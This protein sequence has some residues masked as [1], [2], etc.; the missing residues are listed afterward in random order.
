MSKVYRVLT[1]NEGDIFANVVDVNGYN[2]LRSMISNCNNESVSPFPVHIEKVSD[3]GQNLKVVDLVGLTV[4]S[5][6]ASCDL[7]N[8][9]SRLFDNY[10]YWIQYDVSSMYR[11]FIAN[12]CLNIIDTNLSQIRYYS[13]SGNVMDI[14]DYHFIHSNDL[15]S[16]MIFRSTLAPYREILCTDHFINIYQ[17]LNGSGLAFRLLGAV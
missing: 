7:I 4:D 10:G 2:A 16:T 11:I 9:Y 3:D 6:I 12:K 14:Q 5:F 8:K 1:K 17:E 13:D 15:A